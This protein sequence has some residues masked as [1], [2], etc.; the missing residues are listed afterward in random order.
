PVRKGVR[1]A[2]EPGSDSQHLAKFGYKQELNR[3]L[4]AFSSFAAGFSYISILTGMF[5]TSGYGFFF[6]GPAFVWTWP[7][8]FTGQLLVARQFAELSA[9]YPLAG[10]AYQWSK[11]V[12]GRAWAWHTGLVYLWAQLV[13][14]AAVSVTWQVILPQISP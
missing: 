9:H 1:M 11:Q 10:S 13:T 5:A 4:G 3:E 8:V 12:A 7:V 6:G 2:A 14:V